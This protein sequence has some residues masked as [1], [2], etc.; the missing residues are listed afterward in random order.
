MQTLNALGRR[1]RSEA[2]VLS[3]AGRL[4]VQPGKLNGHS[5]CVN[6]LAWSNDGSLLVS[7][8]DDLRLNLWDPML[9]SPLLAS[10]HT[11]FSRN[12][13]S[14]KFMAGEHSAI[15]ACAADGAVRFIRVAESRIESNGLFKCHSDMAFEV[16]SDPQNSNVFLSCSDD[17]TV[18]QYD[19]RLAS[20]CACT[21]YCN[22]HVLID[23]NRSHARHPSTRVRPVHTTPRKRYAKT[24]R[25]Q[26]TNDT[27]LGGGAARNRRFP[28]FSAPSGTGVAAMSIHPVQTQYLALGCSDDIV[29]VYDQRMLKLPGTID[30]T[31]GEQSGGECGEVYNFLPA[32]FVY[33]PTTTMDE[34][35]G[36]Q[37]GGIH[38]ANIVPHK[39]TSL[40]FD[41]CG[42]T[43]DLLVS[44][45]DEKVYLIRPMD[46]A[47][48]FESRNDLDRS[49]SLPEERGEKD[50][51][52]GYQGHRNR[53][54]MI[55]EAYF[56]GPRSECVMSGSD[57]GTVVVWDKAT[58]KMINRV[59]A[60][61]SVVNCIAPN[62]RNNSMLCCSGIDNNIKVLLSTAETTWLEQNKA[63]ELAKSA[64]GQRTTS[65]SGWDDDDSDAA[66]DE[67]EDNQDED[68]DEDGLPA[69][70][71]PDVLLMYLAQLG[72]DIEE[73]IGGRGGSSGGE[74][75]NG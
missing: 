74:E 48:E 68:D 65:E 53:Q 47:E 19:T 54:T 24:L 40:K 20:E 12:V 61:K 39:I 50:L 14:A 31:S 27:G 34:E 33:R 2:S 69:V 28:F 1:D 62:P 60:D 26:S 56:Y 23:V 37:G 64:A 49:L 32:K 18:N 59:K 52:R 73:L 5:G 58:G 25:P 42:L 57:D 7:G 41:P 45:S 70:V 71:R 16:C 55:K 38:R 63:T 67:D 15:A 43:M 44:Y 4:S 17:G 6:S 13:F 46:G 72:V 36:V 8:S 75:E 51:I 29:R 11:G 10:F 66:D 35:S 9:D 21:N 30:N 3:E 22:T